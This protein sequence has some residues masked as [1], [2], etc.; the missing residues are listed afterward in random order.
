MNPTLR[1]LDDRER[2]W[3]LT[4]PGWAAGLTGA[5]VLYAA[6]QLSPLSTKAT[7]T[8]TLFVL[9][10]VAMALY[11]V[12]GQ[13][14]SPG[15]QLLAVVQYRRAAKRLTLPGTADRRGLVLSHTPAGLTPP[16]TDFDAGHE[17][18]LAARNDGDV[19]GTFGGGR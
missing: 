16:P 6:V 1:R 11:G 3:G 2:Y 9:A 15:R 7:I 8:I 4:W 13:A 14:L 10:F 12:S 5:G 17:L 18:A 19:D